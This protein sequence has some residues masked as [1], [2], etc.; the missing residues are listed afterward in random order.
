MQYDDIAVNCFDN[1]DDPVTWQFE[2]LQQGCVSLFVIILEPDCDLQRG[3]VV[4]GQVLILQETLL[5]ISHRFSFIT[6][7]LPVSPKYVDLIPILLPVGSV[8]EP[9]HGQDL[10]SVPKVSFVEQ[11]GLRSQRIVTCQQ[12]VE[13]NRLRVALC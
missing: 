3:N 2:L 8:W 12:S 9:V 6:K 5:N 4:I 11:S 13:M 10:L 1:C 7:W